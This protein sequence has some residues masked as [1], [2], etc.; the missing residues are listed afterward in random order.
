MA[1]P[2]FSLVEFFK[3]LYY[4]REESSTTDFTVVCQ[5]D[6]E[7]PVHSVVLIAWSDVL[8]MTMTA[9]FKESHEKK[10]HLRTYS[11]KTVQQ[12]IR[13]LYGFEL[14]QNDMQLAKDMTIM[15]VI[16]NIPTLQKAAAKALVQHSKID[17]IIEILDFV[18]NYSGTDVAD[19]LCYQLVKDE[20]LRLTLQSSGEA[21]AVWGRYFYGQFM[22]IG[23]YNSAPAFQ[24]KLGAISFWTAFLY[25]HK[26]RS[27]EVKSKSR[28][29]KSR[30]TT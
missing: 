22:F 3:K 20:R 14:E 16:Y 13:F 5:D 19:A 11:T 24:R 10:I 2:N 12:F 6:S 9:D 29:T 15:G 4:K 28:S 8:E 25:K 1:S 17:N 18:K 7:I 30:S 26:S 27:Q 23:E 21:A